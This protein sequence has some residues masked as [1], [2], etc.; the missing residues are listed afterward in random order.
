MPHEKA[1]VESSFCMHG[2]NRA[3]CFEFARFCHEQRKFPP[4]PGN[5]YCALRFPI[6]SP[7]FCVENLVQIFSR[8]DLE[9]KSNFPQRERRIRNGS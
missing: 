4:T 7:A 6:V 8:I 5:G 1:N 2:I 3:A 9:S